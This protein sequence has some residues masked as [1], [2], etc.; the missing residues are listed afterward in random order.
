M[1][2]EGFKFRPATSG[3]LKLGTYSWSASL[4]WNKNLFASAHDQI[5]I[6]PVIIIV[7]NRCIGI[8]THRLYTGDRF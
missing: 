1:V 5:K 3:N 6:C 8:E 4:I 2:S 7:F